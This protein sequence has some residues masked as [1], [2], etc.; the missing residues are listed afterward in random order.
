MGRTNGNRFSVYTSEEKTVLGLIN[1]LAQENNQVTQ[2]FDV[3]NKVLEEKTDLYGDHKGSWQGLNR[4]TL[5]EEGMRATVENI[6]NNVIPSITNHLDNM[7]VNLTSFGAK[8]DGKNDDTQAFIKALGT[9]K[10]IFIGG[11]VKITSTLNIN[12]CPTIYGN[13]TIITDIDTTLL[14]INKEGFV[15]EG[16][17]LKHEDKKVSSIGIYVNGKNR[18]KISNV[19]IDGFDIGIKTGRKITP[20]DQGIIVNS[21]IINC[22][23]GL[24]FMERSEY[25]TVGNCNINSNEIGLDIIGGNININGCN[26]TSNKT[27]AIIIGNGDNGGHGVITGC[28]INHNGEIVL[29]NVPNGYTITGNNIFDSNIT[30]QNNTAGDIILDGNTLSCRLTFRNASAIVSNNSY[31]ALFVGDGDIESNIKSINNSCQ[32]NTTSENVRV[33]NHV[34]GKAL[35]LTAKK[36]NQ[37]F[38]DDDFEKVSDSEYKVKA[39][40]KIGWFLNYG[41]ITTTIPTWFNDEN[42]EITITPSSDSFINI[43]TRLSFAISTSQLSGKYPLLYWKTS[44]GAIEFLPYMTFDS[45]GTTGF[46]ISCE[47]SLLSQPNIGTLSLCC[48]KDFYDLRNSIKQQNKNLYLNDTEIT[49]I[50]I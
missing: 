10:A 24:H 18:I 39:W 9:G 47:N 22:N 8:C 13:G 42:G 30:I 21:N 33:K 36:V 16:I 34:N 31:G 40:T 15:L 3:I 12:S 1:E 29:N 38:N 46:I 5:S 45:G 14:N 27:N 26:I 19:T 25:F 17:T 35:R 44:G 11:S 6:N 2:E 7:C 28:Q 4:P 48:N 32:G 37:F 20:Y 41:I 23:T 50:G 43:K 49:V